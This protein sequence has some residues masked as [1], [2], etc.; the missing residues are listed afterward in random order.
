[1]RADD[2]DDEIGAADHDAKHGHDD[3]HAPDGAIAATKATE[4][5]AP[6]GTAA[7]PTADNDVLT[8]EEAAKLLRLGRQTLYDAIGRGEVPHRKIGKLIRLVRGELLR[9]ASGAA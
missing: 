4:L 7:A 8:V 1:M 2:S 5:Q 3:D 6:R 9:W